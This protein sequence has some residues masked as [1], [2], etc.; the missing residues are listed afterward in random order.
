MINFDEEIKRYQ[1]S[2]EVDE[3]AQTVLNRDM[4][5]MTDL[6]MQLLQEQD[7]DRR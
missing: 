1:P 2:A 3:T 7:E 5:D 4:T 6:L